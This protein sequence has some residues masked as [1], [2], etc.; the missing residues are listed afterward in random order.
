MAWTPY[1]HDVPATC[2][3]W[4]TDQ[5]VPSQ[6]SVRVLPAVVPT[7]QTS[8]WSTAET[9]VRVFEGLATRCQVEPSQCSVNE[10]ALS[11]PTAQTSSG[12]ITSTPRSW[13]YPVEPFGDAT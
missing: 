8:S 12:A 7:A 13:L 11:S 1:N 10:L 2:G 5:L 9:A 3:L 4:T 6:C